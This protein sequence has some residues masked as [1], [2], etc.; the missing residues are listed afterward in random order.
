MT[1]RY[2]FTR[3]LVKL[4][5]NVRA[6]PMLADEHIH[7]TIVESLSTA[8]RDLWYWIVE[9]EGV[10]TTADVMV[11]FNYNDNYASGLLKELHEFGLLDREKFATGNGYIYRIKV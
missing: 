5:A 11:T 2:Q 1:K 4:R 7:N 8:Q 10:F 6:F 9:C 3:L